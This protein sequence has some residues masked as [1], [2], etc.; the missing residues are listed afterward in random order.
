MA[1]RFYFSSS[2]IQHSVIDHDAKSGVEQTESINISVDAVNIPYLKLP[3]AATAPLIPDLAAEMNR[4]RLA[5]LALLLEN[6]WA[7]ARL[8]EQPSVCPETSACEDLADQ[9][10]NIV[11]ESHFVQADILTNAL[12]GEF[13]SAGFLPALLI[14]IAE[15]LTNQNPEMDNGYR[16]HLQEC[17]LRLVSLR[18]QMIISNSRLVRFIAYK[19]RSS[20]ISYEDLLLEGMVGLIKAVDRFDPDRGIRFSTYAV[21][22]IKQAISRLIIKQEKV[23]RL[24]VALAEKAS[25][26]N[27]IIRNCY[28]QHDRWP[29]QAEI[30]SQC[31]LS[32]EEIKLISSYYQ[33]THSLDA[34]LSEDNDGP[35]LMDTL[36]QQQF[37]SPLNDLIN[38]NLSLFIAHIIASLPE[39]EAAILNMRFGLKNHS[40]MTLQAIADQLQVT[41]ERVRQIQN[42]ALQT[43]KQ[44]FGYELSPFLESND[45]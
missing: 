31:S 37:L 5:L 10:P 39:K 30:E 27:E 36:I 19:Y 23:V 43:L 45:N 17:H 15:Q 9:S 7:S 6:S 26:V 16:Q 24:P 11:Q 44:Q 32:A 1:L 13:A 34:P 2:E 22:W 12:P 35:S 41:R 33:D 14:Q 18:Q 29:S 40:E 21:F 25:V 42:Q 3:E 8:V 20:S 4:A 28:L 38:S